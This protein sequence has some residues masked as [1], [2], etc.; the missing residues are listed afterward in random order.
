MKRLLAAPLALVLSVSAFA[1]N[2]ME[3]VM[4]TVASITSNTIVVKTGPESVKTVVTDAKT[5]W[6]RGKDM[7][8]A[9]DVHT[10]D[11]VVIHASK[12]NDKLLASEVEVGIATAASHS[13]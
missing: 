11:R 12:V 5:M 6:M 13:H 10:G 1:H 7:I 4:G 8:T 3:H 9:R 2:G